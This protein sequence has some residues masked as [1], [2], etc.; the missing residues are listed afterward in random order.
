VASFLCHGGT[1]PFPTLSPLSR[2][3]FSLNHNIYE[4][5]FAR[6]VLLRLECLYFNNSSVLNLPDELSLEH[7]LPQTP[8]S[9]SQ[10]VKTFAEADRKQW[11]HKLGNLMLL[12]R[13]KN[14]SLG[15]LDFVKKKCKYFKENVETLPNSLRVLNLPE[16]TPTTVQARHE[17]LLAKLSASY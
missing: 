6:Y 9:T 2:C 7:I 17:E 1:P 16:F 4:R 12:S 10:W 15:N 14:T 8:P 11:L 3:P 13:R 5:R